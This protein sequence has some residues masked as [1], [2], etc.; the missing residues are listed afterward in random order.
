MVTLSLEGVLRKIVLPRW[1][2]GRKFHFFSLAPVFILVPSLPPRLLPRPCFHFLRLP[3]VA[4]GA[5]NLWW[6]H[7]CLDADRRVLLLH[8]VG[9]FGNVLRDHR[10]HVRLR[11][12]HRRYTLL[13][14]GKDVVWYSTYDR[15]YGASYCDLLITDHLQSHL[16]CVIL[17][18]DYD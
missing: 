8:H 4:N 1:C 3:R 9:S 18:S 2:S 6:P 13:G 5:I 15:T 12:R 11:R 14:A 17:T 7:H 16:W 10:L